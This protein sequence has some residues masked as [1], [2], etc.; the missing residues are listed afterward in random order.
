MLRH[1]FLCLHDRG[2]VDE[3]GKTQISQVQSVSDLPIYSTLKLWL[4]KNNISTASVRKSVVVLV[5]SGLNVS[6]KKEF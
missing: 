6:A 5:A 2:R 3:L 1:R 4:N